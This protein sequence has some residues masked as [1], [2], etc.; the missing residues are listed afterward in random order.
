M[1]PDDQTKTYGELFSFD[2]SAFTAT[3]LLF[4]DVV[5]ALSLSSDGA[6]ADAG[7]AGA[8]YDITAAAAV[9]AGLD[10]YAITY[11][12]GALDVTPAPLIVTP[13]DQTKTYG[14]LF[15]FDGSAFTATG[16]LFADVVTALSL[17]SDGAAADAGVAGAPYDIT[18]AAAVGAGLDN[19]A[20]TYG[21]GALDVTP[22][23]L[24]VTPDDQTKTYGELFS[25]D[26]SAFTA[27]GLLFADVVTALS[28]SSDG[29]AA[30]AGVA[31]APY[32][33]TAAAA[34]GAGLDNY[35]ITYGTGAL[36]VT[37]APLIVTPD[38]QTKTYGELFSFDG[39]A[40]TATGLLFADVVT[41]LSLSSDGAAADAGVAGAPY[42][43]TAAA[44]VGAGLDNYAITYGTGALDVTGGP[45][46]EQPLPLAME[47]PASNPSDDLQTS[48]TRGGEA[49]VEDA[50][51]TLTLVQ[52]FAATLE[53][54]ADAC[55][56][57]LSDADRYLA[58]LSDALDD[59]AN[60]LDAIS[61]DLPPGLENVA[62]IVR[63]AR[64]QTDRARARA[65][66]RL[67]GATTD[68]QRDAIRR[69]ALSEARA[70]VSTASS[71]IRKAISFARADDPELV[72]LQSAT[73]TTIAAAVDSVGIKLSRAVGL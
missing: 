31:G 36:D 20:I 17:S 56:Q 34:V 7:V 60:E 47:A 66:T 35:A 21:T 41:A 39:S 48:L 49:A 68:A 11:G 52:S 18:A 4:A 58:C 38:D 32:D 27:T 73:V 16:L 12:T 65:N 6:A 30:D 45:V 29:A 15:S 67:A 61:T 3:G 37:P 5:T 70:A 62:R 9:G 69:D 22:A 40:F 51:D 26:G 23:P 10:N 24:I 55:A 57:N 14:E 19:Y 42:D 71:E 1:T 64:V 50:G 43:I 28:L 2:G 33:I 8:P 72:S 63:T 13:D 54:A 53:I 25:F 59:F 44:A 46:P